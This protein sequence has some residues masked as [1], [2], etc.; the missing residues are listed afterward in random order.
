M[1]FWIIAFA[2]VARGVLVAGL[3]QTICGVVKSCL[4]EHFVQPE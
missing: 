3:W 2:V 1:W 4:R